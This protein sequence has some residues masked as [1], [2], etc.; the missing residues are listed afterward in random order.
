AI[1]CFSS[2]LNVNAVD[3]ENN[4]SWANREYIMINVTLTAAE[5]LFRSLQRDRLIREDAD[6]KATIAL[7]EVRDRFTTGFDLARGQPSST[8]RLQAVLAVAQFKAARFNH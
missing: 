5:G 8:H 7:Q 3:F 6:P 4:A 2:D 1:Q